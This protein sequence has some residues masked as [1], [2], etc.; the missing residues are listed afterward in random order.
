MNFSEGGS[1]VSYAI[2]HMKYG[3]WLGYKSSLK[4]YRRA[5]ARRPAPF[6]QLTGFRNCFINR[7]RATI[8]ARKITEINV[9]MTGSDNH[10]LPGSE[11]PDELETAAGNAGGLFVATSDCDGGVVSAAAPPI[12]ALEEVVAPGV[13]SAAAFSGEGDDDGVGMVAVLVTSVCAGALAA[14]F[15]AE[16]PAPA[17]E[18]QL[19]RDLRR[20][21]EDFTDSE[22]AEDELLARIEVGVEILVR[23][24]RSFL[25]CSFASG[26]MSTGSNL[27]IARF[28]SA[29][30]AGPA[31]PGCC[32]RAVTVLKRRSR[33]SVVKVVRIFILNFLL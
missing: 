12:T 1:H 21:E 29:G 23:L 16:S 20:P 30:T 11:V 33:E 14:R 28:F 5:T 2:F 24:F 32:E 13:D 31:G 9:R 17:V 6:F 4:Q 15:T 26:K 22:T 7:T 25:L 3:I 8:N 10:E 19:R 18:V 27:F